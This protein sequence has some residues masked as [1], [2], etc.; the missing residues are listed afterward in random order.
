MKLENLGSLITFKD[1]KGVQRYLSYLLTL[2]GKVFEPNIGL[3]DV[4]PE[5]VDA[6]NKTLSKCQIEGLD[7][8]CEVG[9][10]GEL[11]LHDR[12]LRVAT[13]IGEIV[14]DKFD[15]VGKRKLVF[16]RNGRTYAGYR[17]TASELFTFKRIT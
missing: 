6:H 8:N 12:P 14:S 7:K 15:Q 1:D 3:V 10:Y 4:K 11:Y 13:W 17:R 5:D 2:D 9:M 16:R